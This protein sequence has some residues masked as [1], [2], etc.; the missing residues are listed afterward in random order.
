MLEAQ[1][2]QNPPHR[3]VACPAKG[4]IHGLDIVCHFGNYIG[5]NNLLLKLRHILVVPKAFTYALRL[6]REKDAD[7]VL[8]T[9]PDADRLGVYAKDT[10]TGEYVSFTGNMSGA[11][12]PGPE[13]WA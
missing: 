3:K 4:R 9:D 6:A 1:L 7:I 8:A 2:G 13:P 11:P 5:M 12:S 10:K